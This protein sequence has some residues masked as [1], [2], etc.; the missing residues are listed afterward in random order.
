MTALEMLPE[1]PAKTPKIEPVLSNTTYWER[2]PQSGV[3][4]SHCKLGDRVRKNQVLAHLGDPIGN[5]D[6]EVVASRSGI[7]IGRS[8]LPLA[9]EGDALFHIATFDD[10]HTAAATVEEFTQANAVGQ[11]DQGPSTS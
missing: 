1:R 7:V 2:A 6:C 8:Q 4:V 10:P 11:P 3:L 5:T 9:H